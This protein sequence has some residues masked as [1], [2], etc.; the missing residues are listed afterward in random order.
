MPRPAN[1]YAFQ[2]K[3]PGRGT[4]EVC[5][6][7]LASG[8]AITKAALAFEELQLAESSGWPATG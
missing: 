5:T 4:V 2:Q 3:A 7:A 1:V 6:A 8:V